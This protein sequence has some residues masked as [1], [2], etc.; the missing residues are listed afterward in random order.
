MSAGERRMASDLTR[1]DPLEGRAQNLNPASIA[2]LR[3]EIGKLKEGDPRRDLLLTELQ[4]VLA[5]AKAVGQPAGDPDDFADLGV[6]DPAAN[7][8]FSDLGVKPK[9]APAPPAA[10][11]APAFDQGVRAPGEFAETPA[12]A[13]AGRT[14]R[15]APRGDV[16]GPGALESGPGARLALETGGAFAGGTLGATFGPVGMR[17]G[18]ALGATAGAV[19]AES[20]DPTTK[21]VETAFVAGSTTFLTGVGGTIAAGI[22][23]KLIGKPHEAGQALANIMQRSGKVPPPGAV[24][25]S[26]FIRNAEAIG[27]AAFGTSELLKKVRAEAADITADATRN[28]VSGF[29]RFAEAARL[30]FADVDK[31]L[32]NAGLRFKGDPAV[33]DALADVADASARVRGDPSALDTHLR[34]IHDWA[35][36]GPAPT[37]SFEETQ[38]IY[39]SLYDK[40]RS[41]E[42]RAARG[43]TVDKADH[44]F[45]RK[46][47][48]RV[49]KA[50]DAQIDFVVKDGRVPADTKDK[51]L[52]ARASWN[53]WLEGKEL[54]S[55]VLK[56]TKDAAGE[57]PIT[58]SRLSAE[59]DKVVRR[60]KEVGHIILSPN[61]KDGIRRYALAL[62]AVEDSGKQ[63]AYSFIGRIGQIAGLTGAGFGFT[64]P[65]AVL[66]TA[67]H[68]LAFAFSNPQA[69]ALILRGLKLEPGS[70]AAARLGREFL[71]LLEKEQLIP[72]DRPREGGAVGAAMD[73]EAAKRFVPN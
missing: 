30:A 21:P 47:A 10:A 55:M 54:E 42:L 7:D 43:E 13:V 18:E 65:G 60:E 52:L 56:A 23:R 62:K 14:A 35:Q 27:S 64:G 15:P 4:H 51:L 2:D 5:D 38:K 37:F 61:T 67:P 11:P 45:I 25:E 63:G 58:G 31:A 44:E 16:R 12:G 57:G 17:T 49:K 24:L 41:I 66:F 28:Y 1:L 48:D 50:F 19:L 73:T 70:A 20:V 29:Q 33:R 40:A 59:L 68:V 71:T 36:G 8:D 72:P 39:G 3:K 53:H 6:N 9:A 46:Q 22:G 26:D 69:S 34:K 32:P